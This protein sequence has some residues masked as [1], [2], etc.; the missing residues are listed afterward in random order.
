MRLMLPYLVIAYI[1]HFYPHPIVP[2]RLEN[3][4]LCRQKYMQIEYEN[5]ICVSGNPRN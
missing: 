4:V 1:G 3:E 2:I 5:K